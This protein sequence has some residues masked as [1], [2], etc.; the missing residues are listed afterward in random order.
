VVQ[1]TTSQS[2]T[3]RPRRELP[4]IGGDR[5]ASESKVRSGQSNTQALRRPLH[6][7]DSAQILLK[8]GKVQL[9]R[10][11]WAGRCRSQM[12]AGR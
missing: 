3:V 10:A 7:G 2:L 5:G 4:G 12:L 9:L 6:S 8:K 11:G 1:S